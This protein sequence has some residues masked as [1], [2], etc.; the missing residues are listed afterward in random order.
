M[1]KLALKV[2]GLTA[3]LQVSSMAFA[4]EM[5]LSMLILLTIALTAAALVTWRAEEHLP[6]GATEPLIT[7][8]EREAVVAIGRN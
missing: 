2:I 5:I 7:T 1:V 6:T 3:I 8:A 4:D